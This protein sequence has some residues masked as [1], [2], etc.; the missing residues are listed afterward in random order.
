MKKMLKLHML[1]LFR[2]GNYDQIESCKM[3]DF[4]QD[5]RV[6][7]L[8]PSADTMTLDSIR[9]G[10]IGAQNS[11]LSEDIITS[12]SKDIGELDSSL[13]DVTMTPDVMSLLDI[14]T[15]DL[16]SEEEK[17]KK[18]SKNV[19]HWVN[20]KQIKRPNLTGIVK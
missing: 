6:L 5:S 16:I 12:N 19:M 8:I 3:Y 17:M 20:M 9:H 15:N 18:Y 13:T 7:E 10:D 4:T 2:S 14:N 11:S 1:F